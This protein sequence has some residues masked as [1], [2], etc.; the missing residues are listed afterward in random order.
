MGLDPSR[1]AVLNRTVS[2]DRF[3]EKYAGEQATIKSHRLK[4]IVRSRDSIEPH[5]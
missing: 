1:R 5:R 4:V 3:Q 2:Y